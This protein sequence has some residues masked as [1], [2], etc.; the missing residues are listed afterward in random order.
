LCCETPLEYFAKNGFKGT[1]EDGEK[2]FPPGGPKKIKIYKNK[3]YDFR[4][5][6]W[7][8]AI[9]DSL[10][11]TDDGLRLGI[12]RVD[13]TVFG[14]QESINVLV[15]ILNENEFDGF[16]AFSQGTLLIHR[17]YTCCQHFDIKLKRPLPFFVI[18]F[19]SLNF[20]SQ[21]YRF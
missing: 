10:Q 8:N 17:L 18:N 20:W 11:I 14:V 7:F 21:Q 19:A 15:N 12:T 9:K 5:Y 13:E 1:K 16:M 3:K 4:Y 6:G 2:T